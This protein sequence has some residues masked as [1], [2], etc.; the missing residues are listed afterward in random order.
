MENLTT[1][2]IAML[3]ATVRG[4]GGYKK[5]ATKGAGIKQLGNMLT[6]KVG[7]EK[8]DAAMERLDTANWETAQAIIAEALGK[9]PAF[10]PAPD[11]TPKPVVF[12]AA[13]EGGESDEVEG[14]TEAGGDAANPSGE[15]SPLVKKK[16]RKPRGGSY[17]DLT[18][19]MVPGRDPYREGTLSAKTWA[20]IKANPGKTFREYLAMGAR[21]NTVLDSIRRKMIIAK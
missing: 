14:D 4:E 15:V 18:L 19:E 13:E 6:E 20:M 16:D 3:I 5:L 10:V 8:T 2:Q 21:A 7:S 11:A 1:T 17:R 9:S 12:P